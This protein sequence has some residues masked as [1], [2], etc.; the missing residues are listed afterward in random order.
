MDMAFK[1]ALESRQR[2]FTLIELM[3]V[4]AIVGILASIAIPAYR[5]AVLKGQRAEGRAYALQMANTLER[6]ATMQ[7]TYVTAVGTIGMNNYSGNTLTNSAWDMA[8]AAGGAG[9]DSSYTVTATSRKA[10]TQ[11]ATLTV[12]QA[13]VRGFSGTGGDL[14]TCWGM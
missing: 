9:I 10:D 2:G 3:V 12:N 14:R 7:N 6:Y 4:V 8:I 13:G 1:P 11:C 5:D